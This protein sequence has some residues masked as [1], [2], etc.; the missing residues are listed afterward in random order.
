MAHLEITQRVCG[1]SQSTLGCS[2]ALSSQTSM[3]GFSASLLHVTLPLPPSAL[4]PHSAADN[5]V[6][7]AQTQPGNG[8]LRVRRR[9]NVPV[10]DGCRLLGARHS[11][12]AAQP[13]P[14]I[15]WGSWM[16]STAEG[17][18]RSSCAGTSILG[19]ASVLRQCWKGWK[20]VGA[21]QD[22][23]DEDECVAP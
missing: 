23:W 20:T 2:R 21:S 13:W 11:C 1:W 3:P 7:W 12:C 14:P 22:A 10:V 16:Q 19:T 5:R 8:H 4:P 9:V 17:R 18:E 6:A 15:S